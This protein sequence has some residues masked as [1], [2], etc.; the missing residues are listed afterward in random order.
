MADSRLGHWRILYGHDGI[1]P[2]ADAG[3][4]IVAH[5]LMPIM[6]APSEWTANAH[7]IAAAPE[8]ARQRDD[9]LATLEMASDLMWSTEYNDSLNIIDA[10]IAKAKSAA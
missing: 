6:S 4:F 1:L 7:L 3:G 9:L 5:V 2:I 10:A 8:T